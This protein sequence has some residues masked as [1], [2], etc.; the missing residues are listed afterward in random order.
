VRKAM[1]VALCRAA[2][3][4]LLPPTIEGAGVNRA[5]SDGSTRDSVAASCANLVQT[6]PG[7]QSGYC[8]NAACGNRGIT[9]GGCRVRRA[10]HG[11][12]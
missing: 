7:R 10:D 3:T 11:S 1:R 5:V 6:H 8:D 4:R 9:P 2:D 12:G